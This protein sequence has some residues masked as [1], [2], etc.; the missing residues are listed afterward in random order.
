MCIAAIML[1]CAPASIT[2]LTRLLHTGNSTFI[3]KSARIGVK[4]RSTLM[5]L[6]LFV[7]R[8]G[9]CIL[10]ICAALDS[11]AMCGSGANFATR[12][13]ICNE[14]EFV[15]GGCSKIVPMPFLLILIPKQTIPRKQFLEIKLEIKFKYF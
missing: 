7:I 8:V 5:I 2:N 12:I 1:A 3:A 14:C 11:T 4:Y 6:M 9:L 13:G 10:L 15:L